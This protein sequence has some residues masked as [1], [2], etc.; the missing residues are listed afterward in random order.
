MRAPIP[1][2]GEGFSIATDF[3]TLG[4]GHTGHDGPDEP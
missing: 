2:A 4:Q 3:Q 1:A